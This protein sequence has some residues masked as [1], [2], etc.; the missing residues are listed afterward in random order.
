MVNM[1]NIKVTEAGNNFLPDDFNFAKPVYSKEAWYNQTG[2]NNS[3]S[4]ST[5]CSSFWDVQ[6]SD[7]LCSLT[8]VGQ[9]Y[10]GALAGKQKTSGTISG[11][12]KTSGTNTVTPKPASK[13]WIYVTLTVVGLGALVG[14]IFYFKKHNAAPA[15]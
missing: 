4:C 3:A 12:Q 2:T 5:C 11:P 8:S 1:D 15:Q 13:T 6:S 9:I 14:G 7:I 10:L